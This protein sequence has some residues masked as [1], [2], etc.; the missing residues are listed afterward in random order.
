MNVSPGI[1]HAIS[2][3]SV[4]PLGE[5]PAVGILFNTAY[6]L[7]PIQQPSPAGPLSNGSFEEGLS[8]WTWSGN[9]AVYTSSTTNGA[10]WPPRTSHGTKVL[11]FNAGQQ[12]GT[13]VISQVIATV[14]GQSYALA[15]DVGVYAS[16]ANMNQ[17][18]GL[19]V[20]ATG[21]GNLLDQMVS[22]PTLATAGS[23]FVSQSLVFVADSPTTA[24][25]FRDTSQVTQNLDLLLD[26]LTLT[27][28]SLPPPPPPPLDTDKD[29]YP[30]PADNCPT[31]SNPDQRDSDSDGI[32]D[33]CD[34]TPIPP[35]LD[36]DGDGIEDGTDN[37]PTVSN[38]D[39]QDSDS[40]GIGDQ[41][42]T[43]PLPPPIVLE[44]DLNGVTYLM[45]ERTNLTIRS[46]R[47][48]GWL[49]LNPEWVQIGDPRPR[50][51]NQVVITLECRP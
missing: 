24:V 16:F 28:N 1:T 17:A 3:R 13:G 25:S 32:G 5:G 46:D 21:T 50:N 7:T 44:C 26:N 34:P 2:V 35:P 8:G 22:V 20:T 49:T 48:S 11:V 31:A 47:L 14:P 10:A 12:P 19:R 6:L 51:R 37:C 23:S 42:D 4:G 18:L 43:T 30:D 33:A 15:F 9:L 27:T 41:C 45:G 39:Q 38:A 40:D 29:G 36:Q